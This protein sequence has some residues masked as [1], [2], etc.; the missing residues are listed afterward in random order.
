MGKII[1]SLDAVYDNL[2]NWFAV[3]DSR[4]I[5]PTGWHVA[6]V[7]DWTTLETY[8]SSNLG[9]SFCVA[10]ALA[11]T[12]DWPSSNSA[13]TVGNDLTKNN[14]T[15]FTALPGGYRHGDGLFF[16]IGYFGY[17]WGS[18]ESNLSNAWYQGMGCD[19]FNMHTSLNYPDKED[20]FSVRCLRD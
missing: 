19:D 9:T 12:T 7:A 2:N 15:G 17:W 20:G 1:H 6:T 13:G 4:N 14:T 8:V 10:K 3:A 5:A 18:S 11:S 16:T